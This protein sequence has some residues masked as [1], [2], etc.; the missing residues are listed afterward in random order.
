MNQIPLW[1]NPRWTGGVNPP[2]PSCRP[3]NPQRDAEQRWE[4]EGGNPSMREPPDEDPL[5]KT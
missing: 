1:L 2:P 4:N 3:G 5:R